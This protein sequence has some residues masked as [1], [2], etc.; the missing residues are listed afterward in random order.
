MLGLCEIGKCLIFVFA[1]EVQKVRGGVLVSIGSKPV[2]ASM[3]AI[4]ALSWMWARRR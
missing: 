4:M 1:Q 2:E 3:V